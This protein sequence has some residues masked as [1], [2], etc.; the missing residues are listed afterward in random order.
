[1]RTMLYGG[2]RKVARGCTVMR[3]LQL[4]PGFRQTAQAAQANIGG[5]GGSGVYVR[6]ESAQ[7]AKAEWINNGKSYIKRDNA[8]AGR[9]VMYRR[10]EAQAASAQYGS[11]SNRYI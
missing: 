11:G 5:G 9:P 10:K 7:A 3:P 4:T 1:M 8:D 2:G 6:R